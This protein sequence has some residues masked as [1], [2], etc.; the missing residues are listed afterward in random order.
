MLWFLVFFGC[1]FTFFYL[2]SVLNLEITLKTLNNEVAHFEWHLI[3]SLLLEN[4]HVQI[5]ITEVK[6]IVP[7]QNAPV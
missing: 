1:N 4:T 7:D 2:H 5:G 6:I 3:I